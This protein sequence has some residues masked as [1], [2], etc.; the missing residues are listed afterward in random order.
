MDTLQYLTYKIQKGE[1]DEAEDK[2][3]DNLR[4]MRKGR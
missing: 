1:A 4:K 3:Q 2:Y